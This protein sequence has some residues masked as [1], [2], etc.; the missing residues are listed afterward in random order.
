MEIK[1]K[2]LKISDY[3]NELN[4]EIEDNKINGIIGE[5]ANIIADVLA[6]NINIESGEI[7]IDDL[8][9]N[10]DSIKTD[11]SL[12]NE[13][14]CV[15]FDDITKYNLSYS[16]YTFL[17]L[18]CKKNS[19]KTVSEKKILDALKMVGLRED[20][21]TQKFSDI[22]LNE[23]KKI[24]LASTLI[25]NPQIIVFDHFDNHFNE[26]EK[27]NLQLLI[28]KLKNKFN[29]TFI[30]IT[31]NSNFLLNFVDNI[32]ILSKDNIKK[33]NQNYIYDKNI[34]KYIDIPEI[35]EFVHLLQKKGIK[36]NYYDNL[37]DLI[38]AVYRDV[39]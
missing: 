21:L 26:I 31:N 30:I 9:L 27:K 32:Y 23:V 16:V 36:M 24:L 2:C 33:R 3:K 28:K 13:K 7:L 37:L 4:F 1:F 20:I 10:K 39:L 35:V 25:L 38:K 11:Y 18:Y 17:K 6:G 12:L 14:V 15:L 19:R 34:S 8:Q 29:K 5:K 22:S